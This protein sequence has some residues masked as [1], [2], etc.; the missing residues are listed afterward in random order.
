MSAELYKA[1]AQRMK[2]IHALAQV[3]GVIGWDQETMMPEKGIEA[4]AEQEAVLSGVIHE[5]FISPELG[6]ML[7]KLND[8]TDLSEDEKICVREWIRDYEKSVKLPSDLVKELSRVASLSQHAW[9]KA[10]KES[11]YKA[12]APWLKR[13]VDLKR[14]QADAVGYKDVPYDALIDDYE[15]H[16]T[17]SLLDPIVDEVKKDLVPI[18]Q[19]IESSPVKIDKQFLRRSYPEAAQESLNK[20]VMEWLGLDMNACRL[21]RSAHPFCSGI[22]PTDVR[23]TT[24]YGEHGFP[25]PLFGVIHES[26]HALYEQGMD[27]KYEGTPLSEAVSLGIHESQ[28]RFFEN[29][30]GRGRSFTKFLLPKL[31]KTFSK[32][33]AGIGE[34][35]FYCAINEVKPSL[36]RVE[37]DEVTYNLHVILRYELEKALMSRDVTIEDLPDAWN[38]KMEKYLG[39]RPL[40]D[41]QGVLQD[42]H[43]PQGLFGYFP[44]YMLGNIY[45]AQFWFKLKKDIRQVESF[46]SKGELTPVLK[47]LRANVH[48]Q[49][50]RYTALELVER[51]TGEPPTSRYLIEYLKEKFGKIYKIKW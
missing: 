35:K 37:A 32:Q 44:T 50:R 23:I 8:C 20:R 18:V 11:D 28:S 33:L 24:R 41:A 15:P 36:I 31:K 17:V 39:V 38:E 14:R 25:E 4:R 3:A 51:A 29:I 10:K 7:K 9:I 45:A 48:S 6:D 43:W 5:K 46:I 26:G 2:E 49:G 47:W 22:A 19:S 30:I 27:L 21:D 42:T 40:N 16:M 34:E 12:F 13:T 1:C